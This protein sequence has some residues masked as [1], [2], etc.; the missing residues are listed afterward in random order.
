MFLLL[1]NTFYF[2]KLEVRGWSGHAL[3]ALTKSVVDTAYLSQ[4]WKFSVILHVGWSQACVPYP[5]TIGK[6][7]FHVYFF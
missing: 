6:G 7:L 3:F 1:F 2:V 4:W 5:S